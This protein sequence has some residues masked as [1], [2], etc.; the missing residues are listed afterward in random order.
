MIIPCYNYGKYLD[1][2]VASILRQTYQD[3]EIII[4][5]DGSTDAA[6]NR[7]LS[8]YERPKTTVY[9][10][11][12]QGVAAARNYGIDRARGE[13]ILP[14]D[15]DDKIGSAYLEKAVEILDNHREIGVVYCKIN[16]FGDESGDGNWP[17]FSRE[18][19]LYRNVIFT[20]ALFRKKDW[21][22]VGKYRTDFL[23]AGEDW[24]FWLSL[25]ERGAQVYQI[26]EVL[27]FYRKHGQSQRSISGAEE[28]RDI[29]T[30]E[31][32]VQ[33]HRQFYN[34]NLVP[35]L[36]SVFKVRME[37]DALRRKLELLL[38]DEEGRQNYKIIL[39]AIR[40]KKLIPPFLLR[41]I[42]GK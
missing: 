15:A 25:L 27:F 37:N 2:A 12:N 34:D 29:H 40:A 13:Y 19:M 10:T 6:T 9:R 33:H 11:E 21:I 28:L 5:N 24:D 22:A 32:L 30:Y 31:R 23:Y 8:S 16:M 17:S 39:W 1:E 3:F 18:E 41:L 38:A 26:P 36:R 4:V 7:M 14:V 42:L 35:L 20:S